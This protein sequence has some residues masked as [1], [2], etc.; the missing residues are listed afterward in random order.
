MKH[1]KTKEKNTD[2]RIRD[3]EEVGKVVTESILELTGERKIPLSRT[4]NDSL[5]RNL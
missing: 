3:T 4:P 2:K 1:K 5:V